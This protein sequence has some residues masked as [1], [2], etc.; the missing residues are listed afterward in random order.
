M[1]AR[2]HIIMPVICHAFIHSYILIHSALFEVMLPCSRARA[3]QTVDSYIRIYMQ[4]NNSSSS[5]SIAPHRIAS[6]YIREEAETRLARSASLAG[7]LRGEE[8]R[9]NL[10]LSLYIHIYIHSIW[11]D[12]A[13]EIRTAA[14]AMRARS[15]GVL[16]DV[17]KSRGDC[18]TI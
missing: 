14:S 13:R 6:E 18:V 2:A 4:R 11:K 5:R 17:C 3:E 12:F 16:F 8:R 10:L 15:P 9:E 7:L 1:L